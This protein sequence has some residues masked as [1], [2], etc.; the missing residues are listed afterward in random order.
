[1]QRSEQMANDGT[2]RLGT[3]RVVTTF[4][5][6]SASLGLF[7]LDK[8]IAEEPRQTRKAGRILVTLDWAEVPL[9]ERLTEFGKKYGVA[10]FLDRRVDPDQKIALSA[11]DLPVEGVPALLAEKLKLGECVIGK[12]HYIGPKGMANVLPAI[13]A[14]RKRELARMGTRA[15]WNKSK[16]LQWEEAASPRDI[17]AALAEEAG[18]SIENA[19]QIPHDVWPAYDLPPMPLTERL[20]LVLAGFGLTFQVSED[21]GQIRITPIPRENS[22]A[23]GNEG[24]TVETLG[25]GI[26]KTTTKG[27]PKKVFSMTVQKQPAG[28]VVNTVAK[29]LDRQFKYDPSL[30]EKLREEVTFTVK[31]VS[32][33]ELLTQALKPLGLSYKMTETALEVIPLP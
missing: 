31:D 28:A 16:E 14:Q 15:A 7:P 20:T 13:V 23:A 18:T 1:V 11:Q 6:F 4:I 26:K 19:E 32:L 21:G 3:P 17:A 24:E 2:T 8:G 5:F 25:P 10:V 22:L 33:D 30:R 9:R 29:Q 27:P 12:V